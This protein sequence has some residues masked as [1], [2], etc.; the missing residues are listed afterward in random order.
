VLVGLRASDGAENADVEGALPAR[1]PEDFRVSFFE[2]F[3]M[4]HG[5]DLAYF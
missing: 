5:H 4:S 2:Q 3:P 1:N